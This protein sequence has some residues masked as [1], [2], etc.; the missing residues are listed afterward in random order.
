MRISKN[1]NNKKNLHGKASPWT[2]LHK[3][4]KNNLQNQSFKPQK[5]ANHLS[6]KINPWPWV[7]NQRLNHDLKFYKKKKDEMLDLKSPTESQM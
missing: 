7:T 4:I 6:I 1:A 3:H 5:W 2:K